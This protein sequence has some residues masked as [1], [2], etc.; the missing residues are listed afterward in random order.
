M[1]M[2]ERLI[3]G[4]NVYGRGREGLGTTGMAQRLGTVAKT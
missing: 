3:S 1:K 2:E 4:R